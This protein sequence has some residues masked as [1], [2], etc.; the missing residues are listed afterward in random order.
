VAH[1]LADLRVTVAFPESA[2]RD[3]DATADYER[4][5]AKPTTNP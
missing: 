4:A 2:R 1:Q 3:L 5:R